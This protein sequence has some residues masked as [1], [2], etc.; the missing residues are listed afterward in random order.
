MDSSES[1]YRVS[2]RLSKPL[3][4]FGVWGVRNYYTI[5]EERAKAGAEITWGYILMV[6][7]SAA[8]ATGG[9]LIDSAAVVIGSMCVAPFFGPAR[10]VCI[11]GLF[12]DRKIFFGGLIKQIVG[13]LLFGAGMAYAITKLLIATVADIHITHQ[14]LLRAMPTAQ[15]VVLSILIAV[16]AGAA[17]SLALSAD[18]HIV[19]TTWGE[20]IDVVVGV[21]IAI[22]FRSEVTIEMIPTQCYSTL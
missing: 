16:A 20:F 13:L 21:E 1:L 6:L 18:P 8:L 10:A 15:A 9:L 22:S 14:I 19:E 3:H 4:W 5:L 17:A 11:G 12:F 7:T 2:P